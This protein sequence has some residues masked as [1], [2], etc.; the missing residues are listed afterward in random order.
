MYPLAEKKNAGDGGGR[1]SGA[2]A[3]GGA[4]TQLRAS[5]SHPPGRRR[6]RSSISLLLSSLPPPA[7]GSSTRESLQFFYGDIYMFIGLPHPHFFLKE[8]LPRHTFCHPRRP[9]LGPTLPA[10]SG[11]P[12]QRVSP[13]RAGVLLTAGR[14]PA[15]GVQR[16]HQAARVARAGALVALVEQGRAGV[17][18]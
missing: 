14:E 7:S 1:E 4:G 17:G 6:S 15:A 13:E 16:G 3:S 10:P 11:G 8:A 9:Q 5:P 12:P 18:F 2:R